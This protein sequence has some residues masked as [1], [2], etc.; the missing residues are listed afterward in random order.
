MA[1]A[2]FIFQ[3]IKCTKRTTYEV[4]KENFEKQKIWESIRLLFTRSLTVEPTKILQ[5]IQ[6]FCLLEHNKQLPPLS[7]CEGAIGIE[8]FEEDRYIRYKQIRPQRYTRNVELT[9]MDS[10][11]KGKKHELRWSRVEIDDFCSA[12]IKFCMTFGLD[13]S[14]IKIKVVGREALNMYLH[15][16]TSK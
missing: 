14:D 9:F 11:L 7:K 2:E 1:T 15:N 4:F 3:A 10:E 12:F 8:T 13:E 16:K 5:S 6:Q